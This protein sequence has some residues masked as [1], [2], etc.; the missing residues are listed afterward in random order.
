MPINIA[1]KDAEARIGRPATPGSVAGVRRR[2]RRRTVVVTAA[3]IGSR[4]Y[5]LPSGCPK[6]IH[7]GVT[8]YSCGGCYYKPYYEGTQVVYVVVEEPE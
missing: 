7:G 2:T 1:L 8:Y 5:A 3:V 6:V 4:H